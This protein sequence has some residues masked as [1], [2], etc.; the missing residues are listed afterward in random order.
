MATACGVRENNKKAIALQAQ[1]IA[2]IK[3]N[4]GLNVVDD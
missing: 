1:R 4:L 2:K 3:S